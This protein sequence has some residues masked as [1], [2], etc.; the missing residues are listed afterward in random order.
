MNLNKL[1]WAIFGAVATGLIAF[2][3]DGHLDL[4]EDLQLTVMGLGAVYTWL[5]PN[6]TLLATS[7]TWVNALATGL[8]LLIGFL[9]NGVSAQEWIQVAVCVATTAGVYAIPNQ[10]KTTPVGIVVPA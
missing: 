4:S 2:L 6:T 7:K 5:M 3:G 8:T 9:S 10:P 1:V